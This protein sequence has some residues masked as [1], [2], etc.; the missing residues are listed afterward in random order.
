[1]KFRSKEQQYEF[2]FPY[3][4]GNHRP[5]SPYE[6]EENEHVVHHD[7]VIVV[8][9]DGLFD[10][11]FDSDIL[12]KCIKPSWSNNE[13]DLQTAADCL[14]LHAEVYSYDQKY[15]GPWNKG[16]IEA[17]RP[18]EDCVGGKEDDITVMVAQIKFK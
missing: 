4:C 15:V 17:E 10:N 1:M 5:N 6:A 16:A 9:T 12:D 7:D 11:V 13:M 2:N 3:Q 8:G 14:A 18:A